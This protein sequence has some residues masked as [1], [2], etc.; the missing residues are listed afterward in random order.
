MRQPTIPR[1]EEQT[2]L[3]RLR[4]D[5]GFGL[6]ELLVAMVVMMIA[7]LALVA[8]LTSSHVSVVRASRISTAAAIASAEL[9]KFRALRWTEIATPSTNPFPTTGADGRPYTVNMTVTVVCPNAPTIPV[10]LT[11]DCGA[12]NGRPIK[13]ATV[14]VSDTSRVLVRE[15]TTFDEATGS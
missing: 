2:L 13:L 12:G 5:G 9:E 4:S 11:T 14:I 3:A 15:T 7:V 1:E 8:A 10:S 6:I